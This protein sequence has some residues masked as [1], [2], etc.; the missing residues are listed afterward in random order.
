M[1][2]MTKEQR[3][4]I[5]GMATQ[6]G[7]YE[8]GNK[9]D[10]LHALVYKLTGKESIG[11]LTASDAGAVISNLILLKD[12]QNLPRESHKKP[13]KVNRPGMITPEQEKKVWFFMYRLAEFDKESRSVS[14]AHRLC[15]I[16][17]KELKVSAFEKDPF[18]FVTFEHG[19]TLI[20][21]MKKYIQNEKRKS[22]AKNA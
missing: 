13:D 19:S 14:L 22:E 3:Q 11:M 17:E 21:V 20:E 2:K 1:S 4:T 7:I 8:K 18:R 9:N 12:A 15:R 5:Y 10:D 16:I 6:L